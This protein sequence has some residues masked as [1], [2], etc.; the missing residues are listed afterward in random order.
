MRIVY[1]ERHSR[2]VYTTRYTTRIH[3]RRCTIPTRV[4]TRRC[5]IPTGVPQGVPYPYHGPQGVPYPYHGPQGGLYPPVY[6]RV[7]YTHRCTSGCGTSAHGC[8]SGC[9]TSAHGCTLLG[10]SRLLV[11]PTG[12]IPP[13]GVPQG[14]NLSRVYL[15]G[16]EPQPGY[17]SV[18]GRFSLG[19]EPPRAA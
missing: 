6:F 15:R 9:G 4:H 1:P 7:V 19:R 17:T 11:Y 16:C 2:R 13:V 12:C 5:T 18:F 8:T 14:V 3:T 10:V